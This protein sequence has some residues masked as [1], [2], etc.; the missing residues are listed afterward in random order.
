MKFYLYVLKILDGNES[1]ISI[2]GYNSV[3]NMEKMTGNNPKLD[4]VNIKAY[5]MFG[6][7]LSNFVLNTLSG[8]K[9]LISVKGYNSCYKYAKNGSLQSQRRSC[10][11]QCIYN[12]DEILSIYS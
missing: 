7:I 3:T 12:F 6:Q 2:K 4:L 1:L 11:Y 8:N 9:I 5:T 10:Q